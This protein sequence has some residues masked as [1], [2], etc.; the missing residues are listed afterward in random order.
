MSRQ[1]FRVVNTEADN[2]VA[3]LRGEIG[4]IIVSWTLL[5]QTMCDARTLRTADVVADMSNPELVRLEILTSKLRDDIIARLSELGEIKIGQLT[6]HFAKV[7]LGILDT[8]TAAFTQFIKTN[9]LDRKRNHDISHK[10]LPEKW[11]DHRLRHIPY[12][13][14]IRGVALAL[15]LMKQIDRHHI[16]PSAPYLW[17]E[18]R[19][20]RYNPTGPPRAGFLLL[21]HQ[22]LSP[23]LRAR[24][25]A[26]EES[27]GRDVWS[28]MA[29]KLNGVPTT[30]KVSREWGGVLLPDGQLLMLNDYPLNSLE[31]ITST[32]EQG[33]IPEPP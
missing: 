14:L 15:R 26:E 6:F 33:N 31:A 30:V 9:R 20:K 10:E 11:A 1:K 12:G 19:K 25:I 21:P 17:A 29:T 4:E 23:L 7:K 3:N 24:I 18:A 27:E 32:P 5:R 28:D 13:V 2:L 16:G 8:E 22:R